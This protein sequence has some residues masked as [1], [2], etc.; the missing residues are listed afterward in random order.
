MEPGCL[1]DLDAN[2]GTWMLNGNLHKT[3]TAPRKIHTHNNNN[4][5]NIKTTIILIL[6]NSSNT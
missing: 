2:N 4:N 6:F 5:N 1:W 3:K